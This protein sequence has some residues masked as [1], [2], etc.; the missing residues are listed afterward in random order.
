M[1]YGG[2]SYEPRLDR[3][4]SPSS[5]GYPDSGPQKSR[6][7]ESVKEEVGTDGDLLQTS[8]YVYHGVDT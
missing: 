8:P 7:E 5:R 6:K 2:W 4:P 1:D 3:D